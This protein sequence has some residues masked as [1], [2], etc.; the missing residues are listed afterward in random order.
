MNNNSNTKSNH[1]E[2]N[3]NKLLSVS[4]PGLTMPQ[5]SKEKILEKLMTG[6]TEH[7]SQ[8]ST[9]IMKARIIMK[10][11]VA[12]L[13]ATAAVIV[14]AI[15]GLYHYSGSIDGANIVMAEVLEQIE[16][17]D[18]VI[19]RELQSFS[20]VS[21]Q[22]ASQSANTP[23][24][25]QMKYYYSI[26]HGTRT[27][28]IQQDKLVSTVYSLVDNNT[29]YMLLHREKQV[30]RTVEHDT[31]R[32]KRRMSFGPQTMIH[33]IVSAG[34]TRRDLGTDVI[35]G[36]QVQG[37]E[38]L[39]FRQEYFD[40]ATARL[41]IDIQTK[42]PVR[43]EFKGVIT[44]MAMN[45]SSTRMTTEETRITDNFQWG[46]P[47][48]EDTFKIDIPPDYQVIDG[49]PRAVI[50][51]A[52]EQT[53]INALRRFARMTDGKYPSRLKATSLAV[54]VLHKA[55]VA[56]TG[57]EPPEEEFALTVN[58]YRALCRFHAQLAREHKDVAYYG[59][60]VT[61]SDTDAVL[62]RWKISD[63]QYRVI[64]G[65]LRTE[66]VSRERLAELENRSSE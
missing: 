12:R 31:E 11:R 29:T 17:F 64:F 30:M 18:T 57:Q 37:I 53:A 36:K 22:T 54:G 9:I 40:N 58:S 60:K 34:L 1:L 56:R 7:G 26:K 14:A 65:D 28:M 15:T 35:E 27:D 10:N 61:T 32:Q 43:L 66:N 2:S 51:P 47:I 16:T 63:N 44:Q 25:T 21:K 23:M 6:Q 24:I 3:I 4:K 62:M 46:A 5:T 39:G 38:V 42:L 13:A 8:I 52:T 45:E 50:P 20:V 41:W 33:N 59:D 19:Y 49:G 55:Y 48:P